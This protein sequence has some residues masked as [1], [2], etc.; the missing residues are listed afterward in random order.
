MVILSEEQRKTLKSMSRYWAE[1]SRRDDQTPLHQ[2]LQQVYQM[3]GLKIL[4]VISHYVELLEEIEK[5]DP[6][7]GKG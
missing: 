5:L 6:T 4:F 1:V 7:G 3:L 2:E